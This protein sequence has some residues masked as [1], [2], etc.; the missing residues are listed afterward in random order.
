[1]DMTSSIAPSIQHRASI[2]VLRYAAP[3]SFFLLPL[4]EID[5][6]EAEEKYDQ[7]IIEQRSRGEKT[8]TNEVRTGGVA[9]VA[10]GE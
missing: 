5:R 4:R 3:R 7:Q 1:M 8:T 2:E 10:V 9:I 6:T